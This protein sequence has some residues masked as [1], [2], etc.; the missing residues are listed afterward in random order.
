ME[1]KEAMEQGFELYEKIANEMHSFARLHDS[2]TDVSLKD[3]VST[4]EVDSRHKNIEAKV[5]ISK[6][7]IYSR[8]FEKDI[9]PK[10]AICEMLVE[11]VALAAHEYQ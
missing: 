8:V 10:E 4:I 5:T 3:D 7:E 9:N 6:S 11:K 2:Y 1:Y